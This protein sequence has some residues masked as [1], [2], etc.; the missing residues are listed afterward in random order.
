MTKENIDRSKIQVTIGKTDH[1]DHNK[2]V[3]AEAMVKC[4]ADK[5]NNDDSD[6]SVEILEHGIVINVREPKILR[7]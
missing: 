7:K 4:L 5:N 2:T 3:L 6:K 1:V